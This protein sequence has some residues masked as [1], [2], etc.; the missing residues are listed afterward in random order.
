MIF[1]APIRSRRRHQPHRTKLL[2]NLLLHAAFGIGLIGC[3]RTEPGLQEI[4]EIWRSTAPVD[5]AYDA[6][7]NRRRVAIL[8]PLE[9]AM[10]LGL[11]R[12][13]V[14]RILGEPD[15]SPHLDVRMFGADNLQYS[16][17]F[18]DGEYESVVVVFHD[19]RSIDAR[20]VRP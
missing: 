14:V 15:L 18:C 3:G 12:Q 6:K 7:C 13:H 4:S 5:D 17:G 2:R 8:K 19:E 16:L 10:R 9:R 20:V 11:H 1:T